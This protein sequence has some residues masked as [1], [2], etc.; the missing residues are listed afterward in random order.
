MIRKLLFGLFL[1]TILMPAASGQTES[2][3]GTW[4][5]S[6]PPDSLAAPEIVRAVNPYIGKKIV[7]KPTRFRSFFRKTGTPPFQLRK[8]SCRLPDYQWE[9]QT[10]EQFLR[11][12]GDPIVL[13]DRYAPEIIPQISV[14]CPGPLPETGAT[15]YVLRDDWLLLSYLGLNC[16][17]HRK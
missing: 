11:S 9:D 1:M 12:V 16:Y 14:L 3:Y 17:L 5:V 4:V 8:G 13:Y 7:L 15:L 6:V 10:A 2:Y